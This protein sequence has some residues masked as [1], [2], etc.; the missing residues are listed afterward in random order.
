MRRSG[1]QRTSLASAPSVKFTARIK[2][3]CPVTPR[4]RA[5]ARTRR[6]AGAATILSDNPLVYRLHRGSHIV[7]LSENTGT[8]EIREKERKVKDLIVNFHPI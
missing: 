8:N 1:S 5:R 4:S 3:F 6:E 2:R 7:L